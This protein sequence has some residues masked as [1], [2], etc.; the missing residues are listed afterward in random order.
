MTPSSTHPTDASPGAPKEAAWGAVLTLTLSV[1][2]L[3]TAEFLPVSLLTPISNDLGITPGAAGQTITTTAI[4]AAFAGPGVVIGTRKFDRRLTVLALTMLLVLSTL[5][6]AM[7]N[8]LFMLLTARFLLGIGLGGFWAMSAALAMRL[9]PADKLPRAMALIMAGVS[10]ATVLA[11]PLGA[12]IGATMGWR[13]AFFLAAGLGVVALIGQF[14]ALPKMPPAGHAGLGTLVALLRRPL[15]RLCFIA[16]IFMIGGHFAGFTYIRPYLELVPHLNVDQISLTLLAY[17]VAG[18]IGTAL[19]GMVIEKRGPRFSITLWGSLMAAAAVVMAVG[20]Q[21]PSV[22]I[23]GVAFWGLAFG[24]IPVSIQNYITSVA[25]DEAESAGAL[26][27]TTFQI[28]ISSGAILGG[29]L[30][31]G[32]GPIAVIVFLAAGALAGASVLAA[33]GRSRTALSEG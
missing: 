28:A 22:A 31:E 21:S 26:M 7:A 5:I 23:A 33:G 11:A 14:V 9:A 4:V 8:G 29:V 27:L 12:W 17:G 25:G 32:L 2:G 10:G 19:G 6:A 13:M 1:F 30:I 3:V 18:F 20:G 16:M 24:A 15:L